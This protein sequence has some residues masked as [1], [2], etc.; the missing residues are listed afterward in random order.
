MKVLSNI[1]YYLFVT[2]IVVIALLL[3][4]TLVP[5]PGN[6][7]AK[8]VKSGSMEPY[9]KTGGIV[10]IR[11]AS[12]YVVGDV[13]TFGKDTKTQI[14]T[15]HRVV[16][17]EGTGPLRTFTTKGDANDAEDPQPTRFS[18]I[19]GKVV[20]TLPYLGYVLDFARKPLG[21]ALLVGVPALII[22]FDE[23]AKI[24]NE[25]KRMRRKKEILNATNQNDKII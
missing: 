20:F 13:I 14:P 19:S 18:D 21:F 12:D 11:P 3:L 22:I 16:S 6:F 1:I 24:V 4:T 17:I 8:V 2:A 9:I 7:K 5:I 10:F 15:T 25:I 23:I